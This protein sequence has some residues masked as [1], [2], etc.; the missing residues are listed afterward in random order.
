MY[1]KDEELKLIGDKLIE[2]F[3]NL[4]HIVEQ[5]IDVGYLYSHYEKKKGES[6]VLGEC[7]KVQGILGH[8]CPY[9]YLIVIYEPNISGFS[10]GQL[11]ILIYHELL[12]IGE[13]GYIRNHDVVDFYEILRP[14]GLGWERNMDMEEI[15]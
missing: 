10:T 9:D 7:I 13:D 15:V 3:D 11:Q 4:Y 6:Y 12:H 14:Y 2:K 5:E 8:F 1:Y